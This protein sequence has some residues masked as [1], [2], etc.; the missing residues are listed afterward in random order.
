MRWLVI[1]Y[2]QKND[3]TTSV[4]CCCKVLL[5][6]LMSFCFL[7]CNGQA[8]LLNPNGEG[9]SHYSPN[10]FYNC[11][12]LKARL[13]YLAG[14]TEAN[15]ITFRRV[16]S[17][18]GRSVVANPANYYRKTCLSVS[19]DIDWVTFPDDAT[20]NS[21]RD[22]PTHPNIDSENPVIV[23]AYSVP[24]DEPVYR[25]GGGRY[26]G[27]AIYTTK[28]YDVY[29]YTE[30]DAI[31]PKLEGDCFNLF[32]NG[33]GGIGSLLEDVSG[34]DDWDF[35]GVTSMKQMFSNCQRL[36]ELGFTKTKDFTHVTN[37][38]SMFNQC[39]SLD[40][41]K[42]QECTSNTWLLMD[43]IKSIT[44]NTV[45]NNVTQFKN[46]DFQIKNK[47]MIGDET[48]FV[49]LQVDSKYNIG[50]TDDPSSI[51]VTNTQ[52]NM[53]Q[54]YQIGRYIKINWEM[55]FENNLVSYDIEY[56]K[57]GED[58]FT[59]IATIDA[60]IDPS[61]VSYY[62]YVWNE[63][64][65]NGEYDFRIKANLLGEDPII[66]D[67]F[68]LDYD[69][70]ESM[71]PIQYTILRNDEPYEIWTDEDGNITIFLD[72]DYPVYRYEIPSD[73]VIECENLTVK[74]VDDTPESFKDHCS[75]TFVNNG[76]IYANKDVA[77]YSD[78]QTTIQYSCDG[79]YVAKNMMLYGYKQTFKG[80]FE[81]NETFNVIDN[82][83]GQDL[84]IDDCAQIY[85][86]EGNFQHSGGQMFLIINGDLIVEVLKEGNIIKVNNGGMLI[87]GQSD[88]DESLRIV[89]MTGSLMR[90]CYNPTI[91]V[92]DN[93][94][95]TNGNVYFNDNPD[96]HGW[97]I[98][99]NPVGEYDVNDEFSPEYSTYC[100]MIGVPNL[101]ASVHGVYHSYE[102]CMDP[103]SNPV[104]LSISDDPFLPKDKEVKTLYN[105]LNPCSDE[106]SKNKIQIRELGNKW[107]RLI[108]GE[109]IYC[110]NDN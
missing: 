20:K 22:N 1:K 21:T 35:S 93:L 23:Y 57:R 109:L 10:S 89:G 62:S 6:I 48:Y 108:N 79:V 69:A 80:L 96:D 74:V 83:Q 8:K 68:L 81:I 29:W 85:A 45:F 61:G 91:G 2:G 26:N 88:I 52:F 54:A 11:A 56:K 98:V 99:C 30:D 18:T 106:F 34:I 84:E 97:N 86:Y 75:S 67:E 24:H 65:A 38:T 42:F 107:F 16:P 70:T 87:V 31:M 71:Y 13:S 51:V 59:K 5:S 12:Y 102:S 82:R 63:I 37:I 95:F 27:G 110:E 19:Y 46:E 94:G 25:Y 66:S 7:F 43:N 50:V 76:E 104:F 39:Y 60:N 41:E 77:L 3:K 17:A 90:L 28:C 72:P 105:D 100:G 40:L 32:Q 4:I 103:T 55:L 78:S 47:R 73:V 101:T 9:T 64:I 58:S 14:A 44:R 33:N 53:E 92:R 36:R 15:M 49:S